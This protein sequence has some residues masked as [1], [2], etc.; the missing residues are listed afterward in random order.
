MPDSEGA[1]PFHYLSTASTNAT[2]VLARRSRLEQIT[3]INTTA[4][5]YYLKFYDKASA[6]TVGSDVPV[7]T[8]PIPG[9]VS[10]AGVSIPFPSGVRFRLGL[11]FALT[12][13]LA[14]N[15]VAN[16][17]TGIAIDLFAR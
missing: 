10:G 15:D 16:A 12:G 3:A 2:S 17:A 9:S 6:P 14:D 5:I 4:T 13:G 1:Q 7:F 8:V 11:A